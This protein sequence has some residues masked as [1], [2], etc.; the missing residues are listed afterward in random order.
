GVLT[1]GSRYVGAFAEPARD[2]VAAV[3]ALLGLVLECAEAESRGR[4]SVRSA[5][6]LADEV[7]RV[8]AIDEAAEAAEA[9]AKAAA[10]TSSTAPPAWDP[11]REV[12]PP[13]PERLAQAQ[14]MSS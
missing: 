8:I 12:A 5:A 4:A 3:A 10:P 13:E 1:L 9:E 7:A 6:E 14:K 11:A 2:A